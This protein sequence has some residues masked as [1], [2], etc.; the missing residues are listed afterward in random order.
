MKLHSDKI[1]EKMQPANQ[2]QEIKTFFSSVSYS[3]DNQVRINRTLSEVFKKDFSRADLR[4][5]IGQQVAP[6][7]F[8]SKTI[9]ENYN[10]CREMQLELLK[11]GIDV[12]N[13]NA[14]GPLV[15][16]GSFSLSGVVSKKCKNC[17]C[18]IKMIEIGKNCGCMIKSRLRKTRTE[19]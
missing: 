12:P 10:I 4:E 11:K 1:A 15:Q 3:N 7:L 13:T 16:E 5:E 17:G 6:N 8:V 19:R 9:Q 14:T 2:T 18:M